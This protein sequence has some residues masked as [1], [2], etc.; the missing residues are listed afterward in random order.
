MRSR[1]F[2]IA[3]LVF[4]AVWLNAIVPGHT[5]GVVTLP[6]MSCDA[7]PTVAAGARCCPAKG[8]SKAP[9]APADRSAHCAVCYFAARITPPPVIDLTP[10]PLARTE[11]RVEVLP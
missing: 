2:C 8:S 9:A 10:P 11:I 1:G 5:R 3:L 7:G 6:G 4:Q